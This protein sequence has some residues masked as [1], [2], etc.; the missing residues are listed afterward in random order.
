[1]MREST[2]K[3]YHNMYIEG[4]L[5]MCVPFSIGQNWVL[6]LAVTKAFWII[7]KI[8]IPKFMGQT[9]F[10]PAAINSRKFIHKNPTLSD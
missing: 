5:K 4:I 9:H 6:Q 3:D 10:S 7:L 8:V 2:I 1:M